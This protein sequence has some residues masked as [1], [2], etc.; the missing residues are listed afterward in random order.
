MRI[1]F[2][3]LFFSRPPHG[4]GDVDMFHV[5]SG[6]QAM[7][8]EVCLFAARDGETW[9][10]G[11]VDASTTPFP[12][13]VLPFAG[14]EF[15]AEA[16]AAAFQRE[17]DAWRPDAV[18]LGQ[19]FQMKPYAALALRHY[20]LVS[21]FHAH[22]AACHRDILHFK[23]GAPCPENYLQNPDHCRAC[24]LARWT[25]ELRSGTANAWLREYT[26]ARAFE[27]GYHKIFR[28]FLSA[29]RVA[30][31]Y[32]PAMIPPLGGLPASV[33]MVPSGVDPAAFAAAP[34]PEHGQGQKLSIFMPGRAEDPAKGFD[35]LA[36]AAEQLWKKRQ[37]FEVRATL[38]QDCGNAPWLRCLG[39]LDHAAMSEAYRAADLCA[40]PSV[41]E[42]PWG[43]VAIEAMASARPVVASRCGG[44]AE[45]VAEGETGMLFPPGNA[46][47]LAECLDRLL[48]D[49][50]LRERMG[51]AGRMRVEALYSW[52]RIME[53]HYRPLW[54]ELAGTNP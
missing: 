23:N 32:H 20:P 52:E 22:E 2:V 12:V 54:D 11:R 7:G 37:D 47:A 6:A 49:A 36:R 15:R 4:G 39:W 43:L 5:V 41:W 21:R 31:V 24:A 45:I 35:T 33:R 10:R 34:P 14:T 51:R 13:R 3:D 40:V 26:G 44:L 46:D 9:E 25:P 28:D 19:G 48:D 1:A 18:F 42:E 27:P 50:A 38:P 16:V 30:L 8:H 29:L 53:Q 17:V